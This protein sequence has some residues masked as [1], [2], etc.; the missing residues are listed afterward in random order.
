MAVVTTTCSVD[1]TSDGVT[2]DFPV[3]FRVLDEDHLVVTVVDD[4]SVLVLG[5]DYTYDGVLEDEGTLTLTAPITATYVLRISR[6]V[7]ILQ[8]TVLRGQGSY[9]PS[10]LEN[11]ADRIVMMLQQI[12]FGLIDVSALPAGEANLGANVNVAGVGVFKEKSGVTLR[13]RGVKA[14]DGKITV[15]L[16]GPTSEIRVGL[17]V[18]ELADLTDGDRVTTLETDLVAAETAIDALEARMVASGTFTWDGAKWVGTNIVGN[19]PA[20]G[21][22]SA[23]GK[24]KI[25]FPAAYGSADEY[26]V[27]VQ[28]LTTSGAGGYA[29][30]VDKQAGYCEVWLYEAAGLASDV[31]FEIHIFPNP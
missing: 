22:E 2:V 31:D 5:T 26:R 3:P 15:T 28:R 6:V 29:P 20:Q 16:D 9:L 21:T 14:E 11:M 27:N 23:A 24:C 1:H 25:T 30:Q 12:N 8:P 19:L 17:G 13:F 10:T 18:V 7:P 4:D